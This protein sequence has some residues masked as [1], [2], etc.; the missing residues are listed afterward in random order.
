MTDP[1][2]FSTMGEALP[3][4]ATLL[5]V[6]SVV[7]VWWL[8]GHFP[9]RKEHAA[10]AGRVGELE[11][12]QTEQDKLIAQMPKS[13]HMN[14]LKIEITKLSGKLDAQ[15]KEIEGISKLLQRQEEQQGRI[16][17]RLLEGK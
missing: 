6:G 2:F 4:I 16:L 5:G 10:L 3:V 12:G 9:T 13:K 15:G 1:S 17:D 11:A 7:A 8:R 14:E